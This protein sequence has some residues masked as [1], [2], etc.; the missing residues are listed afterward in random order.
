M[1]RIAYL[2]ARRGAY[3]KADDAQQ[4]LD[5][6]PGT[7]LQAIESAIRQEPKEPLFYG[8]KG[9]IL[10]RPRRHQAAIRAFDERSVAIPD[11]TNIIWDVASHTT[12]SAK[13]PRTAGSGAKQQSVANRGSFVF[14][15]RNCA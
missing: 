11:T 15:C 2:K 8:I 14:P 6:D 9:K 10:S 4:L 1:Q 7:A 12:T 13:D 5:D 3:E